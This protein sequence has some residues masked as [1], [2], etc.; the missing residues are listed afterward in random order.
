[1]PNVTCFGRGGSAPRVYYSDVGNHIIE[2]AWVGR[3]IVNDLTALTVGEI[4]DLPS[5][6]ACF[7]VSGN[8]SRVYFPAVSPSLG[9]HVSELAWVGGRWVQTNITERARVLIPTFDALSDKRLTCCG[10][11]DSPHVYC[12][13]GDHVVEL[14][15]APLGGWTHKDV[16]AITGAPA[17]APDSDLTCFGFYQTAF[18]FGQTGV[19]VYYQDR[20]GHVNELA[21]DVETF[22]DPEGN[23]VH[24]DVT[25]LAGAPA[26]DGGHLTCLGIG[27]GVLPVSP[28]PRIYYLD[29]TQHVVE[30]AWV[31]RWIFTDLTALTKTSP[32]LKDSPLA[33]FAA[34]EGGIGEAPHVYYLD[35]HV[36]ELAWDGRR[37]RHTDVTALAEGPS[38]LLAVDMDCLGVDGLAARVYYS[39]QKIV[40][41]GV[42]QNIFE[43]AWIGRWVS[44]DL[45]E[46][47]GAPQNSSVMT[48]TPR[49]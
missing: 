2:L 9:V 38:P 11:G 27:G 19:R 4:S 25:A 3:W 13:M 24:S 30:L 49:P 34:G 46:I 39:A 17:I 40:G 41:Q 31:G 7:G 8:D 42:Y 1:M 33:C 47:T 32:P 12:A 20:H 45:T 44:N 15:L 5:A 18:G 43:L 14:A 48:R 22:Q 36:N 35:G 6:K 26:G 21:W 29:Q 16:T 10:L 28:S 37:W 23:W